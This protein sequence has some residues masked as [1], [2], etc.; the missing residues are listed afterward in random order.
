[1]NA[2]VASVLPT[3]VVEQDHKLEGAADKSSEAL[4]ELRW[5]WTLDEA[6][7]RRVSVSQ[8]A[9]QVDRDQGVIH[10]YARGWQIFALEGKA[11]S[12][13]DARR[14]AS[15]SQETA[16]ATAAVAKHY[17]GSIQATTR[18]AR[19]SNV[20]RS[21]REHARERAERKGTSTLDEIPAAAE[22]T[23]KASKA[24][25]REEGERKSRHTLRYIEIEGDITKAR[26]YLL[27]AAQ[28][29]EGVEFDAE[30]RELL[31]D[32]LDNIKRLLSLLDRAI[33]GSYDT[34]WKSELR[35][36]QGGRAS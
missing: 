30:E 31:A 15:M 23:F 8:Y 25:A 16:A 34:S 35:L 20:A 5:H 29:A 17:G 1:M 28:T 6:N 24:R 32:T 11:V 10:R 27:D 14:L 18:S 9:R 21:I 13:D 33:A 26:R 12:A 4:M 36:I 3:T 7:A 19:R 2:E 22:A